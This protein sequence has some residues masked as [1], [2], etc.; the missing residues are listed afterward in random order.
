MRTLIGLLAV[1]VT[2]GVLAAGG[3]GPA[4]AQVK[5]PKRKMVKG[6][7]AKEPAPGTVEVY[8]AKD[9]FRFRIRDAGGRTIAISVRS[10][11]TAEEVEDDLDAIKASLNSGKRLTAK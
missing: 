10:Q 7:G 9:G 1:A 8:K 4:D 3:P 11:D 6:K 5:D 2:L